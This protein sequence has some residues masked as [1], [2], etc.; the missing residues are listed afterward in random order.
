MRVISSQSASIGADDDRN[1]S[2]VR[3]TNHF[4]RSDDEV[5]KGNSSQLIWRYHCTRAESKEGGE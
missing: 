5:L 2:W 3:G 1:L 4:V